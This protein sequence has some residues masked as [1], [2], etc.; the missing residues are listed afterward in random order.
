MITIVNQFQIYS[1][2]RSTNTDLYQLIFY[3]FASEFSKVEKKQFTTP[4]RIIDFMVKIINPKTFGGKHLGKF[5][6]KVN[7][8]IN[9]VVKL[10]DKYIS[11]S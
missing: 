4:L 1:F 7:E 5:K 3:K 10:V 2:I 11:K 8:D 6:K 9:K